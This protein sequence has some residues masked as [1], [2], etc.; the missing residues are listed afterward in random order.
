MVEEFSWSPSGES[1]VQEIATYQKEQHMSISVV[2][3]TA[4]IQTSFIT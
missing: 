3:N 1:M 2:G 4:L